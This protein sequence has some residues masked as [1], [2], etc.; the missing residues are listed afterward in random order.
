[1]F[2]SN[3]CEPNCRGVD[4][5][6]EGLPLTQH[7]PSTQ[8]DVRD[9]VMKSREVQQSMTIFWINQSAACDWP[10]III[11][12]S[13]FN[14]IRYQTC[15]CSRTYMQVNVCGTSGVWCVCACVCVHV[16]MRACVCVLNQRISIYLTTSH[17]IKYG[18]KTDS[19]RLPDKLLDI[20]IAGEK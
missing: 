16:C 1:M 10:D 14:R 2:L 19:P 6:F 12:R 13:S 20:C 18:D 7:K 4:A 15:V 11:C 9:I 8:H 5:K 3:F 17:D